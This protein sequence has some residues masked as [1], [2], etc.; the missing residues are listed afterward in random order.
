M[1]LNLDGKV[2]LVSGARGSLGGAIAQRLAPEG[3]REVEDVTRESTAA[4]PLGRCG[5]PDEYADA[6]AFPS[7]D[8]ASYITGSSIRVDG[9]LI[10]S[11]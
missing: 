6:V 4:I 8:R 9:G 2:A 5:R 3:A 7:S 1:N 11:V 10:P